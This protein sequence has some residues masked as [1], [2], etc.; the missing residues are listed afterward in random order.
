[1]LSDAPF[2]YEVHTAA[3]NALSRAGSLFLMI[4][5]LSLFLVA[6]QGQLT[7]LVHKHRI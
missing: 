5:D 2:F 1:M 6:V 7:I 3:A 4:F